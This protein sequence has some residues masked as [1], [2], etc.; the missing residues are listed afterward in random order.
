M[1][2]TSAGAR[3][4]WETRRHKQPKPKAAKP[5]PRRQDHLQMVDMT[6]YRAGERAAEKWSRTKSPREIRRKI[7]DRLIRLAEDGTGEH[8]PLYWQ[9]YLSSLN[10]DMRAKR[11]YH[12]R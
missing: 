2:G 12:S 1:S 11:A 10:S 4:G 8:S 9:G 7:D 3:K 5:A 6:D